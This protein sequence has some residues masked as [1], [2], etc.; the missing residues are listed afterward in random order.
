[1]LRKNEVLNLI[2]KVNEDLIKRNAINV[3]TLAATIEKIENRIYK[4]VS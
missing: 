2:V 4:K 3:Y 1:M